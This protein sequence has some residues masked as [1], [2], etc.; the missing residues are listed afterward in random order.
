MSQYDL[1]SYD[2]SMKTFDDRLKIQKMVYIIQTFGVYLGYEFSYYIHGPY[3][4]KLAQTGYET[5]DIY[6]DVMVSNEDLFQDK[7]IEKKYK[8]SIELLKK[9]DSTNKLEIAA[10]LHLLHHCEKMGKDKAI[11]TVVHKIGKNFTR[12]QCENMW[13]LLQSFNLVDNE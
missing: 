12:K 6:H 5:S 3:C 13:K 2:F 8:R 10:S 1:P 4:S 11:D 9:L 7:N